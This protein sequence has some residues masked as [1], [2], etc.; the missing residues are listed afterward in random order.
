[1]LLAY[2]ELNHKKNGVGDNIM[3]LPFVTGLVVI[4]G[5]FAIFINLIFCLAALIWLLSKKIK[6][7]PGWI[8]L[9]NFLFLLIELFYFFIY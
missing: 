1:M 3:P 7:I 2:I 5:Q 4:L 9:T 6:L 8:V